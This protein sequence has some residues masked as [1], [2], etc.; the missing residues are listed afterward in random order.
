MLTKLQIRNFKTLKEAEIPLDNPILL[1]GPHDSGKTTALQALTLWKEGVNKWQQE[2]SDSPPSKQTAVPLP[3][4]YLTH[5][6]ATEAKHMWHNQ[7]IYGTNKQLK[8]IEITVE[9]QHVGHRWESGFEFTPFSEDI[10]YCKPLRV[11]EGSNKRMPVPDL[12]YNQK[13]AYLRGLSGVTMNELRVD[14]GAVH[15]RAG[16]GRA[17]EI[18]RNVCY[19]V[20]ELPDGM[21]RWSYI[22]KKFEEISGVELNLPKHDI[23]RGE[24]QMT[25][26]FPTPKRQTFDLSMLGNGMQQ[27]LLLLAFLELNHD[28]TVLLDSPDTN[29]D[30]HLQHKMFE[31]IF[32]A[33]HT[34]KTQVIIASHSPSVLDEF[35]KLSRTVVSLAE[36]A[37]IKTTPE[38]LSNL[39]DL[40]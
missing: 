22:S 3:V 23:S 2:R 9:G 18:L 36:P 5:M 30:E 11:S 17:A 34:N 7:K 21:E 37:A 4:R 10:I 38:K 31:M 16:D 6:P 20:T 1:T 13:I 39:F 12:A 24:L 15:V 25:F 19:Y 32:K 26:S 29:L 28:G 40:A 35:N 27:L 8:R 14:L 33:V